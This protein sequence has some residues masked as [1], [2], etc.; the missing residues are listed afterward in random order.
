MKIAGVKPVVFRRIL[1]NGYLL[2]EH[3][4]VTEIKTQ[5]HTLLQWL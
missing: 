4:S 1:L 2:L 5:R 3:A